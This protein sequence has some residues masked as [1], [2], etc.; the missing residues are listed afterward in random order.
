MTA[1]ADGL[2]A[3]ELVVELRRYTLHPGQRDVLVDLF[4]REL[5]PGQEAVGIRLGGRFR[6][7]DH[8]DTFVWLRSFPDMPSR[9][10]ALAAFYDGPVWREHRAEANA[11]MIDSDDVLLLRGDHVAVP[12]AAGLVAATVC[13]PRDPASFAD[14]F[15]A[16]VRPALEAAGTPP[17]AVARTLHAANTFPRLPVRTGEDVF[18]W[19]TAHPDEAARRATAVVVGEDELLG[20]PEVLL[21]APVRADGT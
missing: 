15:E 10:R 16:R 6:D 9:A 1:R 18:V 19:F 3:G 12:D 5:A 7:L 14:R 21:L 13:R 20:P 11:T 2:L 17:I 4:E 8:P